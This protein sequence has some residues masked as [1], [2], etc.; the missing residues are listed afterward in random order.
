ML[1]THSQDHYPT[2]AYT[3]DIFTYGNLAQTKTTVI[4]DE[5]NVTLGKHNLFAGIQ[6]EHNFAAN[7]YAQAAAGYYTFEATP[8]EVAAG[9]WAAVFGRS[10]RTFGMTYGN[11]AAHS[12][13][14]S[15]MSTNQ[16][17]FYVQ[18]NISWS[19]RFRMSVGFRFELPFR[20]SVSTG[21]SMVHVSTSSVV[22]QVSS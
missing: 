8:E 7:G 4:T 21:I 15:E 3:G 2:W 12:M 18:D 10:P 13:F 1:L 5:M 17:S 16:W 22:V 19:E 20:V 9:N 11:N 14:T 6:Y